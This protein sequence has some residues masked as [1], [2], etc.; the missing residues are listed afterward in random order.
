MLYHN[1]IHDIVLI[2]LKKN[3]PQI[4]KSVVAQNAIRCIF[5][6]HQV[7]HYLFQNHKKITGT[8]NTMSHVVHYLLSMIN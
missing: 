3:E 4:F 2:P 7:K 8:D 1:Y 6:L 5:C